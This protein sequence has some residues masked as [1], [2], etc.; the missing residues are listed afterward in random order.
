MWQRLRESLYAVGI[1]DSKNLYKIVEG[2]LWR[3]RTGSPWRDLPHWFGPWKSIYNQFNR[4]SKSGV[5][6]QIFE[7]IRGELDN[8][9]NFMDGTIVKAHQHSAGARKTEHSAIGNSHGGRTT[10]IHMLADSHGNPINFEITE[11]QVHDMKMAEELLESCSSE[12]LICDKGYD[13]DELRT[14]A[15]EKSI[16]PMI[17]RK[18]NSKKSNEE[19]DNEL[20]KHR[21]LIE[22]LFARLKHF[23]AFATRYDKLKRNY[24]SVVFIACMLVWLK[25]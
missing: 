23:R 6:K 19:F 4:W 15:R 24:G 3:F 5:W 18:E 12:S 11:G 22:N 17:P 7:L 20:Y 10:K 9:W 25:L 13:S 8:E 21:H 14:K 1:Y 2:I 16:C